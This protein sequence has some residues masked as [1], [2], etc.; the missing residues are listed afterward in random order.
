MELLTLLATLTPNVLTFLLAHWDTVIAII[1]AVVTLIQVLLAGQKNAVW[2]LALDAVRKVAE[3]ELSG[4]EKRS[5][6]V[7]LVVASGP[8]W[9]KVIPRETLEKVAEQA[10]QFLRGE[11]KQNDSSKI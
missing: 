6:V 7:D 10:Y 4:P 1:T 11:L 9:V 3:L 8:A 2:P 5:K